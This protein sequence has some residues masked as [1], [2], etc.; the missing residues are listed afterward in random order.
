MH[1][2]EPTSLDQ[3]LQQS[4]PLRV[5]DVIISGNTRTKDYVIERHLQSARAA[6]TVGELASTLEDAQDGLERLNLFESVQVVADSGP[7][8][9]P[10]TANINITVEELKEGRSFTCGTYIQVRFHLSCIPGRW[11]YF[12]L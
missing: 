12:L 8:E 11:K 5:H 2:S 9:L 7:K 6:Q 4:T 10:D 3:K 1:D